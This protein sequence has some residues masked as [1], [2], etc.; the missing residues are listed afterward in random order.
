MTL[1]QSPLYQYLT[2]LLPKEIGVIFALIIACDDEGEILER[3]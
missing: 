2:L 3:K 1:N